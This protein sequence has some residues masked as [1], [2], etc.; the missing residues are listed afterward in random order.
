M[1]ITRV[2]FLA[3]AVSFGVAATHAVAEEQKSEAK[4]DNKLVGTWTDPQPEPGT[5]Y[6]YIRVL[7]KDGEIA[8]ASPLWIEFRN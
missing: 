8:W 4:A 1:S 2:V 7:Q 5:H 6:Y 3:V